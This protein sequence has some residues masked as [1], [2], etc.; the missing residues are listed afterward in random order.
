MAAG[1]TTGPQGRIVSAAASGPGLRA[2]GIEHAGLD[3]RRLSDAGSAEQHQNLAGLPPDAVEHHRR[4][5]L[6]TEEEGG[7][8]RLERRQ[9]LVGINAT[10]SRSWVCGVDS[11]EGGENRFECGVAI[12]LISNNMM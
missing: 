6:A 2:Q 11:V 3:E 9:A 1:Q 10:P 5:F 8:G 4:F 12:R 7:I